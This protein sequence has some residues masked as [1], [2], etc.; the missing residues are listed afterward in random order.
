MCKRPTSLSVFERMENKESGK[1]AAEKLYD[2]SQFRINRFSH[3]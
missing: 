3:V 2:L 1:I